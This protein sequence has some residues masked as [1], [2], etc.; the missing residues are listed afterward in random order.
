MNHISPV[1]AH[2]EDSVG[3]LDGGGMVT[4]GNSFIQGLRD[5]VGKK[6]TVVGMRKQKICKPSN[7]YLFE[8]F[9]F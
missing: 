8:L 2:L 1:P 7:A 9:R 4:P 6:F 5:N 3:P